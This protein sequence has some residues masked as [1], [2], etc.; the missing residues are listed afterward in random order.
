M[1]NKKLKERYRKQLQRKNKKE[2]QKRLL[3]NLVDSERLKTKRAKEDMRI[4]KNLVE[5]ERLK[6][7]IHNQK[8]N[9]MQQLRQRQQNEMRKRNEESANALKLERQT[10]YA[11]NDKDLTFCVNKFWD[12][13]GSLVSQTEIIDDLCNIDPIKI[14]HK[15]NKHMLS[16]VY[17]QPCCGCGELY[18]Q[19]IIF[20]NGSNLFYT[21]NPIVIDHFYT[22]KF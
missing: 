17:R 21:N 14:I 2:Q 10:A 9:A 20:V 6:K 4:K 11:T 13:T 15:Y 19:K 18:K 16:G 7:T 1:N 22:P 8:V 5:S 3:K 12:N